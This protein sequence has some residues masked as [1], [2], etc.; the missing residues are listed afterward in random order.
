M[1]RQPIG[2]RSKTWQCG[3]I[4]NYRKRRAEHAPI[5]IDG[6]ILERIKSFKF[7]G[8]HITNNLA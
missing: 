5:H 7:L 2:R 8:V 3:A 4:D 6:A 1:M